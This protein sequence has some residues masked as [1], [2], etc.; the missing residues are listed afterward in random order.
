MVLELLSFDN[1]T[2]DCRLAAVLTRG[3]VVDFTI[4]VALVLVDLDSAEGCV[5]FAKEKLFVLPATAD[6]LTTLLP[7]FGVEAIGVRLTG[8][9]F[10]G[11]GFLTGFSGKLGSIVGNILPTSSS[12]SSSASIA[13]IGSPFTGTVI[14]GEVNNEVLWEDI[15]GP[16]ADSVAVSLFKSPYLDSARLS[17]ETS[18]DNLE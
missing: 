9:P 11:A 16:L 12:A 14:V 17:P 5:D 3:F 13:S 1:I 15:F 6:D 18:C 7:G 4:G 2:M 10:T 8:L